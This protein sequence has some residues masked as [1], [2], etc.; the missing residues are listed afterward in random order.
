MLKGLRKRTSDEP[1][2]VLPVRASAEALPFKDGVFDAAVASL[3]LCTVP[4]PDRAAAE[5]RRTLRPGATLRFYEHVRSGED[6][7][8]ARWQDRLERPWGFFAGGCHPNRDTVRMLLEAGFV[9]RWRSFTMPNAWLAGPH[10][11]GEATPAA[12]PSPP[13]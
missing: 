13:A 2:R 11:V 5:I 12:E 1:A 3:V 9:V 7:R 8:L 10:V 6:H 4:R